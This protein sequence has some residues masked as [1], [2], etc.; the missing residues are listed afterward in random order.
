[1]ATRYIVTPVIKDPT[2]KRRLASTIMPVQVLSNN[3]TYIQTT[4]VERLDLLAH[5]FYNDAALWY[6]IAAANGLGKGSYYV[7]A[8]TRLRIP[9]A[10]TI[11]QT[12]E[13]IN[14]SR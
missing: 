11:Q 6:V 1:M 3:D 10:L 5:K 9:D 2:E 13:Q 8:S 4:T 14:N 12:I 7:P